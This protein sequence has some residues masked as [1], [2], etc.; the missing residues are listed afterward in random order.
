[1][2][3]FETP[4]VPVARIHPLLAEW[5]GYGDSVVDSDGYAVVNRQHAVKSFT[6]ILEK[7]KAI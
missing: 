3:Y 7:L 6:E 1:M 5:L 4:P 2:S